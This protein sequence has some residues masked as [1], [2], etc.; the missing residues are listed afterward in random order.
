MAYDDIEFEYHLTSDGWKT[1]D[2]PS[3]RIETWI[4]HP[5]QASPYSRTLVQWRSKWADPNI[6]RA[7]RNEIRTKYKEFMGRRGRIGTRGL[8][9][10]TAIG[11][12]L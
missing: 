6:P 10:E 12:P 11:E 1:G 5:Y 2:P 7:D 9:K 8:A 3:N 4:C